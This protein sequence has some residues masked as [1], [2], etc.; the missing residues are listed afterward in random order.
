MKESGFSLAELLSVIT[1]L[2]LI[3]VVAIP[4]AN[5]IHTGVQLKDAKN[6]QAR[7]LTQAKKRYELL[8]T[9][10]F[11]KKSSAITCKGGGKLVGSKKENCSAWG[12]DGYKD[13]SIQ[14][15]FGGAELF[16]N[17]DFYFEVGAKLDH[18]QNY[19]YAHVVPCEG[20][21]S[22]WTTIYEDG[23]KWSYTVNK[24]AQGGGPQTSWENYC[25]TNS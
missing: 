23:A 5:R 2:G 15:M 1:F 16:E 13:K 25:K 6:M 9:T 21:Q 8:K 3:S 24:N 22:L 7:L 14:S 10:S 17:E 20:K 11:Y 12:F 19:F 18:G 4:K